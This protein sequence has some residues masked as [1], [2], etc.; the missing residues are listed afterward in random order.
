MRY[1]MRN[2]LPSNE[3]YDVLKDRTGLLWFATDRG[4]ACYDGYQ[5]DVYTVADGLT[6]NTVFQL[7]EDWEGKIWMVTLNG[8]LCY[9]QNR[10]VYEYKFNRQ[11]SNFLRGSEIILTF[12]VN[13]DGSIDIG[14]LSSGIIHVS[15]S[16]I[17]SRWRGVHAEA[18]QVLH[19]EKN[20]EGQVMIGIKDLYTDQSK[21][22]NCK[23]VSR[24]NGK[25]RI[26]SVGITFNFSRRVDVLKRRD[27]NVMLI[28]RTKVLKFEEGV[29]S[30]C[31]YAEEPICLFEDS[32]GGF[33]TGAKEGVYY[34]RPGMALHETPEYWLK[35]ESV[36]SVG[37]DHEGGFWLCT[38]NTGILYL[39]DVDI[40]VC[41]RR[42]LS[43]MVF[44]LMTFYHDVLYYVDEQNNLVYDNGK[45]ISNVC[46]LSGTGNQLL[47]DET[48]NRILFCSFIGLSEIEMSSRDVKQK[49]LNLGN[50][51]GA[52]PVTDTSIYVIS[53]WSAALNQPAALSRFHWRDGVRIRPTDMCV[54]S[55]GR[56]WIASITGLLLRKG[57]SL[58]SENH[59]DERLNV[60]INSIA[61]LPDGRRVMATLGKGILIDDSEEII[62][63]GLKEGLPSMLVHTV[64]VDDKG[65]IWAGTSKGICAIHV[66]GKSVHVFPYTLFN[67]F[68][69]PGKQWPMVS[70]GAFV[71]KGWQD[72]IRCSTSSLSKKLPPPPVLIR[73]I[74][75]NDSTI[76]AQTENGFGPDQVNIKISFAG[77]SYRLGGNVRYRYRLKPS[78]EWIYTNSHELTFPFL[79]HGQYKFEV[80]AQNE[81]GVWSD[82]PAVFS[83]TIHPPFWRTWWFI[84]LTGVSFILLTFL[85]VRFQINRIRRRNKLRVQVLEFR[86]QVL[87]AQMNPHFIFNALNTIQ[88][89]VLNSNQTEALQTI[90]RFAKLMRSNFESVSSGWISLHE[91]LESLALYLEIEKTRFHNRFDFEIVKDPD[92]D[93]QLIQVP[94]LL[95]QPIAENAVR[96]GIIGISHKGLITI[97]LHK[98]RA[99]LRIII[100]DNGVGREAS[101]HRREINHQSAGSGITA[102]RLK[103]LCNLTSVPYYFETEDLTDEHKQPAGTRVYMNVPFSKSDNEQ[104]NESNQGNTH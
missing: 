98:E 12:H 17:I 101:K 47:A 22:T 38:Q 94:P 14:F 24:V 77:L 67:L 70:K 10:T 66:M 95:L 28:Y 49:Y 56:H 57:D 88:S 27:G 104:R 37:Q 4:V 81:N 20:R 73:K 71:L 85:L 72:I 34:H 16:G 63:V 55:S 102:E 50:F 29:G 35:G 3:V 91:E 78:D 75:V 43:A 68:A 64:M 65:L 69:P 36:I 79:S 62:S 60:R 30:F 58:F 23:I 44:P 84:V 32:K 39:P 2:G 31:R 100:E 103:T 40:K 97:S 59:R 51:L 18:D 45:E 46:E 11:L 53:S 9:M 76:F 1:D 87:A 13:R 74:V 33:W 41:E 25:D 80:Y 6:D 82:M 52:L 83:F 54:D 26:L 7:R 5:F 89:N 21:T 90:S 15:V 8:R 42:A 93:L 99:W 19:M 86:Q 61:V 48:H 96:H 92:I